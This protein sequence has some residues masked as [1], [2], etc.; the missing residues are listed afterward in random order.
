MP[1]QDGLAT[2]DEL[3]AEVQALRAEVEA[4]VKAREGAAFGGSY[5]PRLDNGTPDPSLDGGGWAP[6]MD[7]VKLEGTSW[8]E[9]L[10][11]ADEVSNPKGES[12]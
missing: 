6:S 8:K 12:K 3:Q 10:A 4:A 2:E 9:L 1:D 7:S 5:D 11:H